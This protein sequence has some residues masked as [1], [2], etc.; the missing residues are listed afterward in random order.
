MAEQVHKSKQTDKSKTE[1][2]E[3]EETREAIDISNPELSEDVNDL[4]DEIDDVLEEN[5]EQF[6]KSYIQKGGE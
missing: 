1:T 3:A 4:L 2:T 5:A 6:V